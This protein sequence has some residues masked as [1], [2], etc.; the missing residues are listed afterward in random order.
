MILYTLG[1]GKTEH[2]LVTPY[3]DGMPYIGERPKG[4]YCSVLIK[5]RSVEEFMEG[6]FW[7]DAMQERHVSAY[8]LVL[9]YFPGARQDRLNPEGDYLFT[10][11]SMAKEVNLRKFGEV[12]V[13]DPHS[14]VVPALVERCRVVQLADVIKITSGKY[15]AVIAPDA[16]A[17]KRA[18]LVAKK[19]GVPMVQAWKRREV[20]TG[21]IDGFGVEQFAMQPGSG[22]VLVVDDICDGGGTFIGLGRVLHSLGWKAHLLTTHGIYSQGTGK[23]LE[24]YGHLY[25]TDS[26]P[27]A[28]EGV[29]E[30]PVCNALL[31]G[32]E[33]RN[34]SY[35]AD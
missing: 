35:H 12:V 8:R 21:K 26:Y 32:D 2:V 16:G 13:L 19:L 27:G 17:A 22:T 33:V 4:P 28:R 10:A 9:P 31:Q 14:D 3:P 29:I 24:L 15:A 34:E 20:A 5:G 6:L 30:I 11:K 25:C 1:A 7:V 23:L 18:G